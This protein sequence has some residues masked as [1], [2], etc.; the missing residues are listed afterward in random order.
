MK[1]AISKLASLLG[2]AFLS[3]LPVTPADASDK[4]LVSTPAIHSIVA[5]LLEGVDEPGLLFAS[6]DAL[7]VDE[8]SPADR[9]RVDAAE[10]V[11]WVGAEYEPALARLRSIDP[12]TTLKGLTVSSTLPLFSMPDPATEDRPLA[13]HDMR[14]WLD[15][16]LAKM[17]VARIA[18]NL[19]RIYPEEMDRILDNEIAL[20]K[21]IAESEASLRQTLEATPGVPLHVPQSDVLYLA[22]RYNLAVP[23]CPKAAASQEGFD[24]PAGKDLYFA[25]MATLAAELKTC[26]AGHKTGS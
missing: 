24:R 16:K 19:A 6:R 5:L 14:F 13:A 11:V 22:W 20:K 26:Q 4:V 23:T 25:M 10:M 7:A 8:L 9:A 2:L 1:S 18:P 17:A 21:K 3:A 12:N 15:P